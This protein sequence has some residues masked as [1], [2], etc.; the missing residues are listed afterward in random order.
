MI[1]LFDISK[2]K[3][4]I[5]YMSILPQSD[6]ISTYFECLNYDQRSYKQ[7][8]YDRKCI[9]RSL[10]QNLHTT[11]FDTMLHFRMTSIVKC[12]GKDQM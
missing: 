7:T 11:H 8:L 2:A 1:R 12:N 6:E 9:F 5:F 3:E 4:C 10:P